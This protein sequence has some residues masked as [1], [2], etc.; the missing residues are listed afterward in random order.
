MKPFRPFKLLLPIA[1]MVAAALTVAS[2]TANQ[3]LEVQ[4]LIAAG[5]CPDMQKGAFLLARWS[6]VN[7][8]E[9]DADV[10]VSRGRGR[11]E[12]KDLDGAI[13]DFTEAIEHHPNDAP[14][15]MARGEAKQRSGDLAGAIS[16]YNKSVELDPGNRVLVHLLRT[17]G[18]QEKGKNMKGKNVPPPVP[19]TIY[20]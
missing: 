12:T 10:C 18:S 3:R 17:M 4:T 7:P 1:G 5:I 9:A 13:A 20:L 19:E 8:A 16:D 14:A 6:G 2:I 15:Y 11:M